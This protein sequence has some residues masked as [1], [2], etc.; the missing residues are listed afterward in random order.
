MRNT[1][2]MILM[3]LLALFVLAMPVFAAIF[4]LIGLGYCLFTLEQKNKDNTH[5]SSE[6]CTYTAQRNSNDANIEFGEVE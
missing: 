1:K 2:K 3:A 4:A 5:N 6:Q